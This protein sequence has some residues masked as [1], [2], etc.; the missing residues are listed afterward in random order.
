MRNQSQ[1]I[2]KIAAWFWNAR[3]CLAVIEI[4]GGEMGPDVEKSQSESQQ[5]HGKQPK[6]RSCPQVVLS[7]EE[8]LDIFSQRHSQVDLQSLTAKS[9]ALAAT[10]G[11]SAKTVRDIWCGRSWLEATFDLWPQASCAEAA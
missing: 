1:Q 4:A 9:T 8:A 5:L 6:P 3:A 11:I 7:M 2:F 10:F